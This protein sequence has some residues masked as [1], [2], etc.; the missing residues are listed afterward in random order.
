M[1]IKSFTFDNNGKNQ[2][3]QL[4][5]GKNWPVVYLIHNNSELYIGETTS[6]ANRMGQHLKSN[7]KAHLNE[8]KVIFDGTYN[9]SVILDYEQKL[10]K[11]FSTDNKF[12]KI[13]N[14]N[15]GQS[16]THDYYDRSKYN[17]NFS[18]LW[19]ELINCGMANEEL[20]IIQNK[21][22]F[23]YSP[24]NSLTEEQ[25]QTSIDIINHFIDRMEI[26]KSGISLVRGSAGTGKTI[27][28]ISLLNSFV[29]A[30]SLKEEDFSSEQL[31]LE[32]VKTLLRLKKCI[33]LNTKNSKLKVGY[34]V[35]LTGIRKTLELVFKESGQGLSPQM[36]MNANKASQEDWD[37]LIVDEAHRL[38]R[39]KNLTSY[40]SY[41]DT[42]KSL[43][44]DPQK[45]NQ[46]EWIIK[47]AKYKILFYDKDQSIKSS[48][49]PQKDIE[50]IL[51]KY[52]DETRNYKLETQ[53][54]CKGGDE[55]INYIKSIID[56][57]NDLKFEEI[58]NYEFY[59]FDDIDKM[60]SQIRVKDVEYGLSRVVAG[61]SWKWKTKCEE[62]RSPKDMEW[63]NQLVSNNIYDIEIEGNKYIWNI[64]TEGWITREDSKYT[65]GCVHTTQGQ[66]LNYVGVIFGK[67]IDYNPKTKK[68]EID[69]NKFYDKK[70]KAST[71]MEEL[72]VYIK[73]SY[74][75]MMARGIRGCYVYAYNENLRNYLKNYIKKG[76]NY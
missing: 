26:G 23:K 48:D 44:V 71:S 7:E 61:Y 29:N 9:K 65:I 34:V 51:S 20:N 27:L 11:C 62:S 38:T 13:L 46:L 68:I 6:A 18:L 28:G 76:A 32:K 41:D 56:C 75:T 50:Y 45:S 54:R 24:Y 64:V 57:S 66:D 2:L 8:I 55:Y 40:K 67:E 60:V 15:A 72:I 31:D 12:T 43:G 21:N 39:R 10:I 25:N 37:I 53:M 30:I 1:E 42:C 63:Y 73:N 14:K 47:K 19:S 22:I 58:D 74:T 33:Q 3:E 16:A 59:I 36:I 5:K 4:T 17:N 70:V 35:P 49:V 69:S 52:I